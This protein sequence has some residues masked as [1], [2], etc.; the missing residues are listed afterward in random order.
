MSAL[1]SS[2]TSESRPFSSIHLLRPLLLRLPRP[3]SLTPGIIT[4]ATVQLSTILKYQHALLFLRNL[5]GPPLKRCD[6]AT[7][8]WTSSSDATDLEQ[9]STKT[10]DLK[11]YLG[12]SQ[13]NVRRLAHS[14]QQHE[15]DREA[16]D[17]NR[18]KAIAKARYAQAEA[19]ALRPE[20]ASARLELDATRVEI[21]LV[22]RDLGA[23]KRCAKSVRDGARASHAENVYL[24][25][26]LAESRKEVSTVQKGAKDALETLMTELKEQKAKNEK[27][28]SRVMNDTNWFSEETE[29]DK[30]KR[31]IVQKDIQYANLRSD[32]DNKIRELDEFKLNFK[33]AQYKLQ[34]EADRATKLEDSL[35][36]K[37]SEFQRERLV[38]QNLETSLESAQTKQ[39]A[40]EKSL[41]QIQVELENYSLHN[42]GTS[43]QLAALTKERDA[44]Q[45]RLRELEASQQRSIAKL[46]SELE[47]LRA[48]NQQLQTQQTED[49]PNTLGAPAQSRLLGPNFRVPG[50]TPMRTAGRPRASSVDGDLRFLRME[51]ELEELRKAK[52]ESESS[53]ESAQQK[54]AKAK[55]D[56]L[57]A[58]N[59]K[60]AAESIAAREIA[61]LKDELE[62][63]NFDLENLQQRLDDV[64][65]GG[66][67]EVDWVERLKTENAA[68]L[69]TIRKLELNAALA[70]AVTPP[71]L[72]DSTPELTRSTTDRSMRVL[73]R[74]LDQALRDKQALETE[75][76][77]MDDIIASHEDEIKRLRSP[78]S[79][80]S[81]TS[82]L[83]QE[84]ESVRAE[85]GVAQEESRQVREE[86]DALRAE[87][88]AF[89][90]VQTKLQ[91]TEAELKDLQSL[92]S[93]AQLDIEGLEDTRQR[94]EA[95]LAKAKEELASRAFTQERLTRTPGRSS[96]RLRSP[97]E[98]HSFTLEDLTMSRASRDRGGR[99]STIGGRSP[100]PSYNS[101]FDQSQISLILGAV[102]R[103]RSERDGL[104]HRLE[105]VEMEIKFGAT[106][107][108]VKKDEE[109]GRLMK[110][111][112]M[113]QNELKSAEERLSAATAE[114][115]VMDLD[116]SGCS[117][118]Q[119]NSEDK[120]VAELRERIEELSREMERRGTAMDDAEVVSEEL[121]QK[122]A[123]LEASLHHAEA[124]KDELRS[125]ITDLEAQVSHL[126]RD[127]EDA[128]ERL[129]VAGTSADKEAQALPEASSHLDIA[130][131]EERVLR[132][133]QQI[134]MHQHDIKRLEMN[135]KML[136]ESVEELELELKSCQAEKT[137]LIED[138]E[139]A[140]AE[141]DEA[142]RKR[143]DAEDVKD[144]LEEQLATST[145]KIQGLEE[146]VIELTNA[147]EA[148][149]ETLVGL[150]FQAV[151]RARVSESALQTVRLEQA[152]MPAPSCDHTEMEEELHE[153]ASAKEQLFKQGESLQAELSM[154]REKVQQAQNAKA[155]LEED[156]QH[157]EQTIKSL[158]EDVRSA[159]SHAEDYSDVM[160]D[161]ERLRKTVA[162]LH[163]SIDGHICP[164]A[165]LED[166][167]AQMEELIQQ[168]TSER[169]D[170]EAEIQSLQNNI[171]SL[172]TSAEET[173]TKLT[174]LEVV[175]DELSA[176]NTEV[177][178]QLQQSE[179]T[180]SEARSSNARLE[181]INEER[182]QEVDTLRMEVHDCESQISLLKAQLAEAE[183]LREESE[184]AFRQE[185]QELERDMQNLFDSEVRRTSELNDEREAHAVVVK[186]LET[187]AE[188]LRQQ[189]ASMSQKLSVVEVKLEEQTV[190]SEHEVSMLRRELQETK[191]S[192]EATVRQLRDTISKLEKDLALLRQK[193]PDSGGNGGLVAEL[194]DT[195]E[196]ME[197]DLERRAQSL[198]EADD[199]LLEVMKD[200]KKL[201]GK[202][203]ILTRA[204][205]HYKA[206]A[207]SAGAVPSTSPPPVTKSSDPGSSSVQPAAMD[208]GPRPI[209]ATS[210]SSRSTT[211]QTMV[212][213][214]NVPPAT[215]VEVFGVR[216]QSAAPLLPRQAL[217]SATNLADQKLT[218]A[219]PAKKP[220]LLGGRRLPP[221]SAPLLRANGSRPT[222]RS[223]PSHTKL[224]TSTAPA[225]APSPMMESTPTPSAPTPSAPTPSASTPSAP[226]LFVPSPAI[227][228][229]SPSG[230]NS[231]KRARDEDD[232]PSTPLPPT[233]VV[234][235]QSTPHSLRIRR[236]LDR[237]AGGFTPSRGGVKD[238]VA[239]IESNSPEKPTAVE[240]SP[241]RQP[242][243][244]LAF[245]SNTLTSRETEPRPAPFAR[246]ILNFQP[247]SNAMK[248]RLDPFTAKHVR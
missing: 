45:G 188:T 108:E 107:G 83:E 229:A 153:M 57:A 67:Q 183:N 246:P 131:L 218:P 10:I 2:E 59:A 240:R 13:A 138:S 207:S 55:A 29:A 23:S 198:E 51:A 247:K 93:T 86:L 49:R 232:L 124:E 129:S 56:L 98:D 170:T 84:L 186:S 152:A 37:A 5:R 41:K 212:F 99:A 143:E 43:S 11:H 62:D 54:L 185:R 116:S 202:V 241:E 177:V 224:S 73:Q 22:R 134:G 74:Q 209:A 127:L 174:R 121:E 196:M 216:N 144:E 130:T 61:Q 101:S 109:I 192:H 82:Q 96:L 85:L 78:S 135:L 164:S 14:A 30:L 112:E 223:L 33:E 26:A 68:L 106:P 31:Q 248:T 75:L 97:T 12:L 105:F 237:P 166:L 158:E 197:K 123:D 200:R 125:Q 126:R 163:A 122:V 194:K 142:N 47:D 28:A 6:E 1:S 179:D 214:E 137:S 230:S 25:S 110:D 133:N 15:Q 88:S 72:S 113:L 193:T 91:A 128:E 160:N 71:Q 81:S 244:K 204:R 189:N 145:S 245:E 208:V 222:L 104:R 119:G 227:T 118:E 154:A 220:R 172:K 8:S 205:D 199:K 40:T 102:D 171:E 187:M 42:S 21:D 225:P 90:D 195:I 48:T 24:Q 115:N 215:S 136:E 35:E 63:R 184:E 50:R 234:A 157:A 39:A 66:Q 4:T 7:A 77:E 58:E 231:R 178:L 120:L 161:N 173:K 180:L 141:R 162:D 16:V 140:R 176:E 191:T 65:G 211:S 46:E 132:R 203:D 38:R 95:D 9:K 242:L 32:L 169:K 151:G 210:A 20:A 3:P 70:P 18:R 206:L 100:R 149:T 52:Q 92:L 221:I 17:R 44:L 175:N 182:S 114:G 147:E 111:V 36:K 19:N 181:E 233:A 103:L 117:Q 60:M 238:L 53:A 159:A 94:L 155:Q 156:L 89:S 190:D 79:G 27:A 139:T 201:Q 76:Q 167:K 146:R 80:G 226:T 213:A 239:R 69:D 165:E 219:E 87:R 148:S 150:V 34:I 235:E 228:S 217:G 236:R 64:Q 168:R 243:P